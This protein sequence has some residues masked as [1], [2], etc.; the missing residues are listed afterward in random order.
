MHEVVMVLNSLNSLYFTSCGLKLLF[1]FIYNM[2]TAFKEIMET[3]NQNFK[4]IVLAWFLI[5]GFCCFFSNNISYCSDVMV[6]IRN[7]G[8][9]RVENTTHCT[10]KSLLN[11]RNI[12]KCWLCLCYLGDDMVCPHQNLILQLCNLVNIKFFC[13]LLFYQCCRVPQIHLTYRLVAM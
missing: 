4:V 7:L 13:I 5:C 2:P 12:S 6:I 1:T 10:K 9:Y 8:K 3:K 11:G